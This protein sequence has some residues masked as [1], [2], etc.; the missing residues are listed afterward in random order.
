MGGVA[1]EALPGPAPESW[2]INRVVGVLKRAHMPDRATLDLSRFE[3]MNS[4]WLASLVGLKR[5]LQVCGC[6]LVL[7]GLRSYV[8]EIFDRLH[9][10]TYFEI[11]RMREQD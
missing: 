10:E 11:V 6:T 1:L 4:S 8:R 5:A 3:I 7:S 9:F 2:E